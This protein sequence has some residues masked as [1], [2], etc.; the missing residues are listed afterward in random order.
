MAPESNTHAGRSVGIVLVHGAC[1]G[2]W[3]WEDVVGPVTEIGFA[4]DAVDLPLMSLT[5]DAE[6][7]RSAVRKMK[8]SCDEV[9]LVGHSYGGVVITA[10][11]HEADALMYCAAS[12]PEAGHSA[13]DVVPQLTTPELQ[14]SLLIYEDGVSFGLDPELA[15]P[16]FYG[17]CSPAQVQ[18]S[19]HRLR[20]V[21]FACMNEV[22]E[23]PAWSSVPASYIVCAQ[24]F[25]MARD[26]Q[27][28][29]ALFLG[30]SVTFDCD[31][32]LFYSATDAFIER[33]VSV[34]DRMRYQLAQTN[35]AGP[36]R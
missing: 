24:D 28:G 6:V 35:P 30:D 22:I 26:Y 10:A 2:S 25:A 20:P 36:V 23:A 31:H 1:H 13:S 34:A 32:S 19:L 5:G 18:A 15:V 21:R 29:R 14:A 16:A 12:M 8:Q 11:G 3:C 17:K 9:L 7:V 27:Q 4:V 33:L